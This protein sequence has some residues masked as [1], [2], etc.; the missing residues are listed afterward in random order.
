MRHEAIA[1]LL[2]VYFE[3]G[4]S[5]FIWG[6]PGCG[7][8]SMV[9]EW[10]KTQAEK[11]GRKWF[12]MTCAEYKDVPKEI[13]KTLYFMSLDL[14]NRTAE[15]LVGVP[16]MQGS[17]AGDEGLHWLPPWKMKFMS[18]PGL[19][20]VIFIDE[21]IQAHPQIQQGI[22]NLILEGGI[23]EVAISSKVMRIAASNRS[24]DRCG[25]QGILPHL[26]SRMTHMELD[27]PTANEWAI[28]ATHAGIIPEIMAFIMNGE[29]RL[30]VELENRKTESHNW[31]C[32]RSWAALS[33]SLKVAKTRPDYMKM[34][35]VL[36]AN[37]VGSEMANAF[38][39]YCQ[40][41]C[42]IDWEKVLSGDIPLRDQTKPLTHGQIYAFTSWAAVNAIE[43]KRFMQAYA[44]LMGEKIEKDFAFRFLSMSKKRI[45]NTPGFAV[46]CSKFQPKFLQVLHRELGI[47][48]EGVEVKD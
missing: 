20:G 38:I 36:A 10:S 27:V 6:R 37:R 29:G 48:L 11:M 2:D 39:H 41:N 23:G 43:P 7:K 21:L 9:R 34:W 14:L 3:S 35:Q 12:D 4:E 44:I 15:D 5:P 19:C 40:E 18:R 31:P 1:E 17:E 8:T 13:E 32:P 30:F 42:Q 47:N 22:A 25:F 16:K 46:A 28:W 26:E 45:Q 33:A 24:E